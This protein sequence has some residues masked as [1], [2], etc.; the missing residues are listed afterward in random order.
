[1]AFRVVRA[2]QHD[3]SLPPIRLG[4]RGKPTQKDWQRFWSAR[5]EEI[6]TAAKCANDRVRRRKE[7]KKVR[8]AL[9]AMK[10]KGDL[11][12][13]GHYQRLI[14][15]FFDADDAGTAD[16]SEVRGSALT[17]TQHTAAHEFLFVRALTS[18][19][20]SVYSYILYTES[21]DSSTLYLGNRTRVCR[22]ND[23]TRKELGHLEIL[24]TV[25]KIVQTD[26]SS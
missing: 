21:T 5:C 24:T 4:K 6:T 3:C 10:R 12:A 7:L 1:V 18:V 16:P 14:E 8:G 26:T 2:A 19:R 13:V 15:E 20:G 23:G 22:K 17:S 25:Y 9:E 11:M